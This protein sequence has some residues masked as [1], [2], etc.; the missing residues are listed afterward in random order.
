MSL[1][2]QFY[3]SPDNLRKGDTKQQASGR[4]IIHHVQ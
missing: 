2:V 1:Q 4:P 3:L